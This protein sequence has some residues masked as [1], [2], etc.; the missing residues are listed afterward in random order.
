ML[1]GESLGDPS[2]VLREFAA[3]MKVGGSVRGALV[4]RNVH[5]PGLD[6]PL[7]VSLAVTDIVHEGMDAERAIEG[8]AENR[9]KDLDAISRYFR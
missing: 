1:G 5:H 2:P 7:A 9:G 6:D 4:G 8:M 3:G